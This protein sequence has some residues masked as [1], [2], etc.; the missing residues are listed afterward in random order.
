L[1][2]PIILIVG[3]RYGIF[4]PS[5][6]GAFAAVYAIFVGVIIYRDLTWNSFIETVRSS[7]IDIGAI[8]LIISVSGIFGY[9]IVYD[10]VAQSLSELVIGISE[11]PYILL[12]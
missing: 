10:R 11:N 6:S 1:I 2:F 7:A 3:I 12:E 5:E 4:T 9:G 8:M